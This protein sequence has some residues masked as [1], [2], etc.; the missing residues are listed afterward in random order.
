M[1]LIGSWHIAA[2]RLWLQQAG[3]YANARD[4]SSVTLRTI[5]HMFMH[6]SGVPRRL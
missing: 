3:H 6:D 4:I 2:G 1:R 5:E